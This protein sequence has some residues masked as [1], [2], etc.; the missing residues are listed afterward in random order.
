MDD[1]EW[2]YEA[3]MYGRGSGK[4]VGGSYELILCSIT[5]YLGI[6]KCLQDVTVENRV[7][8]DFT[9]NESYNILNFGRSYVEHPVHNLFIY[10]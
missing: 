1:S 10:T 8:G 6:L 7:Y 4:R 9:L 2:S 3:V 5:Q